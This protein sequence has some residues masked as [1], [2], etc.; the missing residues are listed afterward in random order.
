[1]FKDSQ[2]RFTL[3]NKAVEDAYGKSAAE[4]IGKTEA[5]LIGRPEEIQTFVQDDQE[6]IKTLRA[7]FIPEEEVD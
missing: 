7:K 5:D 1:L 4:I 2:G 3:V 6:V